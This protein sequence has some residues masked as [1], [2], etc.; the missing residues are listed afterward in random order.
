M[1]LIALSILIGISLIA[2]PYSQ[3][4]MT[5]TSNAPSDLP[6]LGFSLPDKEKT[7]AE[8]VWEQAMVAKGGRARL[9]AVRNMVISTRK[10]AV[11]LV[12][13][14]PV[15]REELLVFPNKYWFWDDYRPDVFGLR[16]SMYNYDTRM[17]Y[18]VSDGEPYHTAEPIKGK[19]KNNALRNDQL[20]FL[21]ETKLLKPT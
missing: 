16:V 12:E 8:R 20:S 6:Y 5:L 17:F 15:R 1:R 14:H 7:E 10:D 21:L 3:D 19:E 18:V 2:G 4:K 11:G 9:Y 13:K